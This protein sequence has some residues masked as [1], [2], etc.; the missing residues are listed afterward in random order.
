M[1]CC[2]VLGIDLKILV[3]APSSYGCLVHVLHPLPVIRLEVV[4]V[5]WEG[6]HRLALHIHAARHM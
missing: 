3:G 5:S 6:L 2:L 1:L 4:L